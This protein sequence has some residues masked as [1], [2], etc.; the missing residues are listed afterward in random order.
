MR[1]CQRRLLALSFSSPLNKYAAVLAPSVAAMVSIL[2]S[3]SVEGSAT[4]YCRWFPLTSGANELQ[5]R[6][7]QVFEKGGSEGACLAP[8]VGVKIFEKTYSPPL[9]MLQGHENP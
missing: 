9:K 1:Q 8:P 2:I 6:R 7:G 5:R 4:L 3:Q